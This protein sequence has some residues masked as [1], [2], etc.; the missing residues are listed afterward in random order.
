MNCYSR[1]YVVKDSLCLLQPTDIKSFPFI[2]THMIEAYIHILKVNNLSDM[3]KELKKYKEVKKI[4]YVVG[5]YGDGVLVN[6]QAEN[7]KDI[8]ERVMKI[9]ESPY[10]RNVKVSWVV[11]NFM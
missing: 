2:I 4:V 5:G 11:Q 9:K 10:A 8:E 6:M 3:L 7:R 1:P